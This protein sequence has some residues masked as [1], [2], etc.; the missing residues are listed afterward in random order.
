MTHS[1]LGNYD[2]FKHMDVFRPVASTQHDMSI[3]H[4]DDYIERM[5]SALLMDRDRD[6]PWEMAR[7][8]GALAESD[9]RVRVRDRAE[10]ESSTRLRRARFRCLDAISRVLCGEHDSWRARQEN[11][12]RLNIG[13]I[14][15]D[16]TER[17]VEVRSGPPEPAGEFGTGT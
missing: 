13:R 9:K 11:T 15:V 6:S 1:L 4:A 2:V 3:F 16:L 8:H 17:E 14:D 12:T 7:D 5:V 10:L